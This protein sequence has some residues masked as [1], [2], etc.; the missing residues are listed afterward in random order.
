MNKFTDF[1]HLSFWKI[2]QSI[3]L[4][5]LSYGISCKVQTVILQFS[6]FYVKGN[7]ENLI[8]FLVNLIRS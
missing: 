2:Y 8:V 4:N 1:L 5:N 3:F 7:L 6:R